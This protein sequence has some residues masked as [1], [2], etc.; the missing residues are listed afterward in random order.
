ME[1]TPSDYLVSLFITILMYDTIPIILILLKTKL[2]IW[3]IRTISI[4]N[5]IIG[6][7][8]FTYYAYLATGTFSHSSGASLLWTLVG[9]WLMCKYCKRD[10]ADI[11]SDTNQCNNILSTSDNV[12]KF[13]S[14]EKEDNDITSESVLP[15]KGKKFK[16]NYPFIVCIIIIIFLLCY[17]CYS[18]YSLHIRKES[19]SIVT[20][21]CNNLQKERASLQTEYDNLLIKYNSLENAYNEM[22][23]KY[24]DAR[25][26]LLTGSDLLD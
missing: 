19:L 12:I 7:S 24:S 17:S 22:Q 21:H 2:K 1:Y 14:I 10:S 25:D 5:F 11:I 6:I 9:Y 26:G 15:V 8:I 20:E 13:H 4:I 23:K 18:A 3:Q 16:R